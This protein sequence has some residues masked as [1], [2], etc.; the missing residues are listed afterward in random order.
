LNDEQNKKK[1]ERER[2]ENSE[3]QA[4]KLISNAQPLQQ[5][6]NLSTLSSKKKEKERKV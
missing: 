5:H 6:L 1:D 4:K 3:I 2:E